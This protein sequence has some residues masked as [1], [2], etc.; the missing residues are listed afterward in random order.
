MY[1]NDVVLAKK[2]GLCILVHGIWRFKDMKKILFLPVIL[3]YIVF[4]VGCN[5]SETT[6]DPK[7]CIVLSADTININDSLQVINCNDYTLLVGEYLATNSQII[8][9]RDTAYFRHQLAG[10]YQ[11]S[12]RIDPMSSTYAI[13][14]FTLVVK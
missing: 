7:S 10:V 11:Y 12:Y 3:A 6:G 9:A 5:K 8:P 4:Q 2:T 13:G 1:K 14:E